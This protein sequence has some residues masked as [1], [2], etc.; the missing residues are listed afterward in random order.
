MGGSKVT[1][2]FLTGGSKVTYAFLTG[3]SKV[4]YAAKNGVGDSLGMR[5]VTH[6]TPLGPRHAGTVY[7]VKGVH[8]D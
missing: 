4:M 7:C 3:G 6:Y 5:L 8:R 2:A 1:Y